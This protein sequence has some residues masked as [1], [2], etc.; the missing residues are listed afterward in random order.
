MEE[1]GCICENLV[2]LGKMNPNPAFM[3]NHVHIFA[4]LNLTE[5]GVQ[6]LDED[7]YL[8]YFKMNQEEV[9]SK[10]GTDEMPHALMAAALFLYRQFMDGNE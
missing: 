9:F 4:A 10:M 6:N 5:T 8:N 7:E 2:Y 1:T 3:T